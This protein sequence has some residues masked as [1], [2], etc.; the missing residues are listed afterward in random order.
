MGHDSLQC[1]NT[2]SFTIFHPGEFA[3]IERKP[4]GVAES[5]ERALGR[6]G[7]GGF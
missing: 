4:K 7:F 5:C 2:K 1:A 3:V 6:I